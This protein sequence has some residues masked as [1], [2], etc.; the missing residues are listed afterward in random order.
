MA[1]GHKIGQFM[2]SGQ[3]AAASANATEIG[4]IARKIDETKDANGSRRVKKWVRKQ[5]SSQQEVLIEC[6]TGEIYRYLI[7]NFQ[8]K[9]RTGDANTILSEFIPYRSVRDIFDNP[10][11]K[12]N[13]IRFKNSFIEKL[14]DFM[15]VLFSSI[16]LEEND[17]SDM[18]YG[19]ATKEGGVVKTET[20]RTN[21][22]GIQEIDELPQAPPAKFIMGN[23]LAPDSIFSRFGSAAPDN[24][25][26]VDNEY[27]SFIKI[28]HGQSL[29]SMRIADNKFRNSR[30]I[31]SIAPVKYYLPTGQENIDANSSIGIDNRKKKDRSEIWTGTRKYNIEPHFIDQVI[32][33]FLC[34]SIDKNYIQLLNY[35][36]ST[37][38][39]FDGRLLS[40]FNVK[41]P[42]WRANRPYYEQNSS[43]EKYGSIWGKSSHYCE[44][45]D[46]FEESKYFAIAKIV[47]THDDVYD[48][49]AKNATDI[50]SLSE[51]QA[52]IRRK[53]CL[54]IDSLF[55]AISTDL[56]F[57]I[58]CFYNQER[59]ETTIS[60]SCNRV[61]KNLASERYKEEI[62]SIASPINTRRL[63]QIIKIGSFYEGEEIRKAT[64]NLINQI[65]KQIQDKNWKTG[66]F[67][68]VLIGLQSANSDGRYQ[69]VTVPNH[70][71]DM[72]LSFQRYDLSPKHRLFKTLQ[73]LSYLANHAI[74]SSSW[75]RSNETTAFYESVRA[76]ISNLA[77][78]DHPRK[79][80]AVRFFNV[81]YSTREKKRYIELINISREIES[82]MRS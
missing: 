25:I 46:K 74:Q 40:L 18:N 63:D 14:D 12:N 4:Y 49:I 29:N 32:C 17:L 5:L 15:L 27:F 1:T 53:I 68:G 3:Q 10:K 50:S 38:P 61:S 82:Y 30:K 77:I 47:F 20:L 55:N 70:V 48:T 52:Q 11:Y 58:Y 26:E 6:I 57:C 35:Q 43:A 45:W 72:A 65:Y 39:L 42:I 81:Y 16:T 31:L 56:D 80:K 13:E 21:A 22:E 37:L 44:M 78:Q 8:P 64:H 36:P 9:V 54:N 24:S 73:E 19:L 59:I 28:D 2:R 71:A 75:S 66:L 41:D 51:K 69:L 79:A 23:Q 60:S 62:G 7:A 76:I 34:G 67:G 33:D